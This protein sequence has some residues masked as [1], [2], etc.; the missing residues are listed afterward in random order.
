M[1][2]RS[3]ETRHL[4]EALP[5]GVHGRPEGSQGAHSLLMLWTYDADPVEPTFPLEWD[6]THPEI[7]LRGMSVMIGPSSGR[8]QWG[9]PT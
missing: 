5:P 3:N 8:Y 1:L 4:L 2:A 6:P 7:V 9:A